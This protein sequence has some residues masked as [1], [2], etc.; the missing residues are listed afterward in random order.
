MA[1]VGDFNFEEI[2]ATCQYLFGQNSGE[3]FLSDQQMILQPSG[4][5][6]QRKNV[7]LNQSNINLGG[8]ACS[9]EDPYK[10]TAFHVLAQM[11]GGDANSLLFE[12]LRENLGLS[13]SSHF[14]FTVL[15]NSGFYHLT[16]LVD[17]QR[18][19]EAIDAIYQVLES[20]KGAGITAENLQKTKNFIRGQRLMDQES[21]LSQ[22]QTISVLEAIGLGY[23]FYL[24]RDQRLQNVGIEQLREL[25]QEYFK[26]E[27][28]FTH[29]LD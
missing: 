2:S 3:K 23:Q 15:K 18:E 10:S 1:I 17:K 7:G 13:Y 27:N 29:I 20:A 14:G 4:K 24:D 19:S 25:A 9:L 21:V 11:I 22:A 26:P 16:A 12:E 28:Y 5:K 6:F 8:W